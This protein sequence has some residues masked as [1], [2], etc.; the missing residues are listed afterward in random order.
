MKKII[1]V[2]ILVLAMAFPAMA[3]KVTVD[4]HPVTVLGQPCEVITVT[5]QGGPLSGFLGTT[6][7]GQTTVTADE[8][9]KLKALSSYGSQSD[10]VGKA[11]LGNASQNLG[12]GAL[13]AV[14]QAIRTPD[15]TQ[16]NQSNSVVGGGTSFGAGAISNVN[17]QS[18]GQLQGQ[19]QAQRQ[20]QSQ[21]QAQS[22]QQ[23]GGTINGN[24][25]G[26]NND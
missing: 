3:R 19:A 23:T 10:G 18:Q 21:A 16:V 6:R 26:G 14:G 5:D 25:N 8:K 24:Q 20:S 17:A 7:V 11:I 22:Q 2:A 4:T 15:T 12:A 9:G 13:Y 1:L